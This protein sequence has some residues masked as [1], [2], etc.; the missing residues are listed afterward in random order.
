MATPHA[1]RGCDGCDWLRDTWGLNHQLGKDMLCDF[2]LLGDRWAVV[3]CFSFTRR[4]RTDQR[5]LVVRIGR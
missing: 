2:F 3:F 5:G 4:G 1:R